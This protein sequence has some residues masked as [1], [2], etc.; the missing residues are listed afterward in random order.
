MVHR[1]IILAAGRGTRM[2]SLTAE[3]P[4]PMLP[5]GGKP[6]L[7][8][9]LDALREAGIEHVCLV[10]GYRRE[11]IQEHLASYPM[12]IEYP[13]QEKL[14]GTARAVG[15]GRE[16][17]GSEPVLVTFGDIVCNAEDYRGII[18]RFGAGVA[19]VL[20]A[21]HVDDPWQGAA[22]YEQDG[23]VT[24]I[25]EKPPKGTSTT[26]WNSAGLYVFGPEFF[27][28]NERVPLSQRGEYEL[29]SAVEAMIK[30]ELRLLLYAIR[31]EWRD[32]GRPED[33]RAVDAWLGAQ[34]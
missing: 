23:T 21:K 18:G 20:G 1:A 25:Q 4:K 13:V 12:K 11:L 10:V 30:A 28:F 34:D 6:L 22:I 9:I 24:R 3:V 2:G 33:L 27:P 31:G 19:G 5:A 26:H 32:V 17:A 14:E 16:F 29:T 7:E 8:H 15:L